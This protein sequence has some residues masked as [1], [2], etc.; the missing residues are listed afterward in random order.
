MGRERTA[1]PPSRAPA[2]WSRAL[3]A[4]LIAL[5]LPGATLIAQDNGEADRRIYIVQLREPPAIDAPEIR[6]RG[7]RFDPRTTAVRRYAAELG[8][9]HD[10]LLAA[11]GAG[12][13]ARVYSYRYSFNGFAAHLTIEQATALAAHPDVLRV[14]PDKTRKL[15]ANASAGFLGL[16]DPASG[17]RQAHGLKGENIIIAVID[18][19]ITPDHPSFADT[20]P[21]KKPRLCRST[22]ASESLLGR[23]LCRRFRK[24]I[25]H[26]YAAPVAWR[27]HCQAG[28]RFAA[29]DCSNKLIGARFYA[30]GFQAQYDMDENEFL[31]PRDADGHGT[32]IASVAAGQAV[33]ATL[34][35]TAV[36][37]ISGI[38][39]RARLAV[40]KACW[41][42][43]G[44]TRATCAMSD[45]QQAIEDAITDGAHIINY[46]IGT[47]DGGPTDP[48]AM[49]LLSAAEAGLVPVVA[50]GNNGPLAD[51]IES[52]GSA[53][54]VLTVAAASRAGPRFDDALRITAPASAAADLSFRE[55]AFTPTLRE[56]GAVSG[57]LVLADDGEPATT[58]GDAAPDDA[59]EN[60]GNAADL[61]GRIALIR[62]G[63]C[64]FQDKIARAEAAGALAA[65]VYNNVA[66]ATVVMSGTRGSVDIPAVMIGN[67]D[68]EALAARLR[69][70]ETVELRIEKGYLATRSD[71]GN[72][73]ASQSSRGANPDVPEVL[74]PDVAA[75]GVDILG[76]HTPEVAN[77]VR[78]ESYQYLTGTSMAVPQVAGVAALLR[79]AHPQWSA[80]A[81]RS[82][83]ST[84]AR[85]D[86]FKE[87]GVTPADSFDGGGGYIVPNQAL[88]PGLVFDAGSE[89]YDAFACGA[90]IARIDETGCD[91]LYA[92]GYPAEPWALN[93]PS[94]TLNDL[95]TAQAVFRFATNVEG[96]AQYQAT[97]EA[98]PGI[99]VSV[100]PDTLTLA[101]G[102]IGEFAVTLE[103]LGSIERLGNWSFGSLTWS[104]GVRNVRIPLSVRPWWL[105]VPAYATGSGASGTTDFDVQFGYTGNYVVGTTGLAAPEVFS[106]FVTDDP[107][108]FYT[109]LDDGALPDHIRRFRIEVPVGVRYLRV[110]IAG[111]DPGAN[112]DLDLYLHC[113][114]DA[115]PNGDAV[116][117]SAST[118]SPEILDLLDPAAGEYVIDVH[119]YQTDDS[120]GGAGASFEVGVWQVSSATNL[121]SLGATPSGSAALGTTGQVGLSWAG[122]AAGTLYL[123]LISHGNGTEIFGNTLVEIS[124]E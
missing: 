95:V 39:P 68:G 3:C 17:L 100:S 12:A 83:L 40:Y 69:A 24:R 103:N 73:L 25:S 28:E 47:S 58:T 123:G 72:V 49:A 109:I 5:L 113:P 102:E 9:R 82:A 110:A 61:Q 75:P 33:Q 81:I 53:P 87:D 31:S 2:R 116:L 79:E 15:R 104:N 13:D 27:G 50:A 64:T 101:A 32:H 121:G 51:S 90:G 105:A 84:T 80:A 18:S 93:L 74:K 36:A 119:G 88:T 21:G 66:G 37:T 42:R 10:E 16:T 1:G 108:D 7:E 78:G 60:L 91:A 22:W 19:G 8:T 124:V 71:S 86:F 26:L 65:V 99:G 52:P 4:L 23:W 122:L 120:A 117:A 106:G 41:L 48:D 43:K 30:R 97:I 63:G 56:S 70:E 57:E 54:W 46:S 59:C 85:Q 76:A 44:A 107:L 77:G 96:P 114:D 35:G 67:A 55:A 98:P 115:C 118:D 94:I 45:L 34:G 111:T 6:A 29:S 92:A 112:D 89:D 38:A 62:R 20:A 14:T 11:V